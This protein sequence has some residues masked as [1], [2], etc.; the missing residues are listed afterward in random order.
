MQEILAGAARRLAVGAR[1][2]ARRG[3]RRGL[4]RLAP[5]RAEDEE[6]M[7]GA[8]HV[9]RCTA[10][11]N[12]SAC[13]ASYMEGL[14]GPDTFFFE[15][16]GPDTQ[17]RPSPDTGPDTSVFFCLKKLDTNETMRNSDCLTVIYVDMVIFDLQR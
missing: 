9:I 7:A 2:T 16:S 10:E 15:N 12:G 17:F 6:A 5:R 8:E 3:A 13:D 4:W 1:R 14:A 11:K